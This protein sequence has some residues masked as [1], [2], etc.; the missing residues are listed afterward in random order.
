MEIPRLGALKLLT[1]CTV[2]AMPDPSYVCDLYHSSLQH[3]ILNPLSKVKD[4]TCIL[5]DISQFHKPLSHSGTPI[6]ISCA[7]M[8]E[9]KRRVVEKRVWHTKPKIYTISEK[10]CWPFFKG[11]SFFSCQKAGK[12][13]DVMHI[14][15]VYIIVIT[16]VTWVLAYCL[17]N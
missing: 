7:T 11:I 15:I 16:M 13:S 4:W 10:M 2:T 6:S 3:R 9:T 5:M 8:A 14:W 1:Y 12:G 17:W